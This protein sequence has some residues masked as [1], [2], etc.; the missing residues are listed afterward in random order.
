MLLRD[1][2]GFVWNALMNN[3]E[4]S[5]RSDVLRPLLVA[6]V[7][8]LIGSIALLAHQY[9]P[10]TLVF[11]QQHAPIPYQFSDSEYYISI[12]EGHISQVPSPYCKRVLYPLLAGSLSQAFHVPLSASFRLD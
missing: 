2:F 9:L 1:H 3:S 10:L 11:Q 12:A 4:A 7:G 6:L 8:C 5:V